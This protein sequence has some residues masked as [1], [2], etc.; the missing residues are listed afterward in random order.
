MSHKNALIIADKYC[1]YWVYSQSQ[2]FLRQKKTLKLSFE[3]PMF[4]NFRLSLIPFKFN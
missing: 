2:T 1:K 4:E 3:M